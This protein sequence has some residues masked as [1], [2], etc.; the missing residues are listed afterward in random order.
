MSRRRQRA[1]EV[2]LRRIG[3]KTAPGTFM[4]LR[5]KASGAIGMGFKGKA[6]VLEIPPATAK[7]IGEGLI[8]AA[9]E[10]DES[11]VDAGDE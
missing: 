8:A 10:Y 7:V 1:R 5:C 9:S 2:I 11:P 6:D 3:V 4:E